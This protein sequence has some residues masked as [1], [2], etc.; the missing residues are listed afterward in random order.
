MNCWDWLAGAYL[1]KVNN[2]KTIR[3]VKVKSGAKSVSA[4]RVNQGRSR[5]GVLGLVFAASDVVVDNYG[6]DYKDPHGEHAHSRD[7]FRNQARQ[8]RP[9]AAQD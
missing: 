6:E 8:N 9:S 4:N 2:I 1:P 7:G 3:K 5:L